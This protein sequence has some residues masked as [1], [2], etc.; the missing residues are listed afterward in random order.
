MLGITASLLLAFNVLVDHQGEGPLWGKHDRQTRRRWSPV[1]ELLMY[2]PQGTASYHHQQPR[3][4]Y[5]GHQQSNRGGEEEEDDQ[6][7]LPFM[8]LPKLSLPSNIFLP[9]NLEAPK[10]GRPFRTP[11]DMTRSRA[12]LSQGEGYLYLLHMRKAG[13]SSMRRYMDD[14]LKVKPNYHLYVTEGD[15]FNVSCFHDQ[16]EMVMLTTMRHPISRILSSYWFEGINGKSRIKKKPEPGIADEGGVRLSFSEWVSELRDQ[17][18]NLN[19]E[20]KRKRVW[21]S[22]DNYYIRTLTS[23]YRDPLAPI[24]RKDFELAKR[25]LS[26]FDAIVI[27]EWMRWDNQT[28]YINS[29]LGETSLSFP[30]RNINKAKPMQ[31]TSIDIET[32][33]LIQRL[34]FWDLQLY[35]YAKKLMTSRLEAFLHEQQAAPTSSYE[36]Y[37]TNSESSSNRRCRQPVLDP[38]WDPG[39]KKKED[40]ARATSGNLTSVNPPQCMYLWWRHPLTDLRQLGWID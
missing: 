9:H 29:I 39:L 28:S 7:D 11:E 2:H 30:S 31:E 13:G 20:M 16:G 14:L 22:V 1:E 18:H 26:A 10:G 33:E 17:Y 12:C 23:R 6:D 3:F 4:E 38:D 32:L 15:S 8:N 35:D 40:K 34:N 27:T 36:A 37:P 21:V 5:L 24:T 25:V 19:G